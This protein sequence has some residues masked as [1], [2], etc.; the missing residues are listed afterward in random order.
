MNR[1]PRWW[2][3][4]LANFLT[5]LDDE[6]AKSGRSGPLKLEVHYRGGAGMVFKVRNAP[7]PPPLMEF[8][9]AAMST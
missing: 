6:Y 8:N 3:D 9:L 2:K 1:A 5:D 7:E 4:A